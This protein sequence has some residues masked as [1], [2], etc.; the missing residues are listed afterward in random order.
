MRYPAY[1]EKKFIFPDFYRVKTNHLPRGLKDPVSV[2]NEKLKQALLQ[3][4][5]KPGHRV[6]I[7]VGSRGIANISSLVTAL[8]RGIRE[9]GASPFIIPAM[10]SHGGATATGQTR[11][12]KRLGITETLCGAPVISSMDADKI[13]TV[14]GDVPVYFSR[15]ALAMDHTVCINR[16]KPHTK[17]K[18]PVESGLYK[19]LCIGMGKHKG[20]LAYHNMA[21]KH[22]FFPLLKAMG[23]EIIRQSNIRFGVAVVE[24]CFDNTMAVETVMSPNFFARE[25][26]LLNLARNNF[27]HL[28]FKEL[29]VLVIEQIGKEISGSGMDPNVTGRTFDLM[30]DDFSESLR[31]GRIAI[32]NLSQK[33][34]GNAIGL[35]NADIITEKVFQSLDYESTIMNAMTSISLRKAFIPVRLPSDEKAIQ[36]AFSTLGPIDPVD[37][38]AVIIK[39][40][41]HVQEF[42]ASQALLQDLGAMDNV[43][44]LEKTPLLFDENE[45]IQNH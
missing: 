44:I 28:P 22:G 25:S 38:R 41:L 8:C 23:D 24:D 12:L 13:G 34:A 43:D 31:V 4:D 6:A 17:F 42:R 27:P 32:L 16:I 35:G 19:M 18:G 5:I 37:V 40:T 10:G 21:L 36:A 33:T 26:K 29:D 1:L 14:M 2:L 39:D 15:D 7:G 45:N 3:S 9:M 20:A 30:E 11:V